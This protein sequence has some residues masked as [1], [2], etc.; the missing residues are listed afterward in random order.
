MHLRA[1]VYA[2]NSRN[3]FARA[4]RGATEDS[5]SVHSSRTTP[6]QA[7]VLVL[8]VLA[9]NITGA[10]ASSTP[11]AD[12]KTVTFRAI[13]ELTTPGGVKTSVVGGKP[14]K[15]KD[16][17]A[18][19]FSSHDEFV[20]TST[21]VGPRALLTAAHCVDGVTT[22][23]KHQGKTIGAKC[24]IAKDYNPDTEAGRKADWALCLLDQAI[25][26]PGMVYE[27]VNTDE[28]LL[29]KGMK[30]LLTG[31]GCINIDLSGGTDGIFRIATAP[32][33]KLP[34][35]AD[36]DLVTKSGP[37]EGTVCPG[38]SGS[39][40]F[41]TSADLVR[42]LQVAV[43]SRTLVQQTGGVEKILGTSF[44]SSVTA[45]GAKTLLSEWMAANKQQICGLTSG[46]TSCRVAP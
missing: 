20:C 39:A 26:G 1:S 27:R 38:D 42:R 2:S 14:A 4:P 6:W 17:P 23:L 5:M 28:T 44:L 37:G 40:A 10:E 34:T 8:S 41:I 12:E 18:S 32:I 36:I 16:W 35:A 9:S 21:L 31:F 45:S 22:T 11:G 19:F 29:V 25:A 3:G 13:G 33:D 43:N 30:L 7:V 15:A 24:T 46:M